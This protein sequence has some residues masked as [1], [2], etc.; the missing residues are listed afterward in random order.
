[1]NA[2][3]VIS[4]IHGNSAAL[5]AVLADLKQQSI[6][7]VFNL[8]DHFSGPLDAAG[9]AE[10]LHDENFITIRGN[11]DRNLLETDPR[12]MGPSDKCA[13][14]VLS[15]RTMSWLK[16]LPSTVNYEN[17]FFLCHGTPASD[18]QYLLEKIGK[19]GYLE[20]QDTRQ[21]EAETKECHQPILLCGHSHQPRIYQNGEQ[22]IINPGSVGCPAYIDDSQSQF[23]KSE[24]GSSHARYAVLTKIEAKWRFDLRAVAYDAKEMVALAEKNLRSDWVSALTTGRV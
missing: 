4:D 24:T 10:I 22:I 21:I 8:G 7:Q 2:I 19:N 23:H 17:E 9:T 15:Q 13:F 18:S 6:E 12:Q 1:M 16:K 20:L 14:E 11:H 5:S 3:A